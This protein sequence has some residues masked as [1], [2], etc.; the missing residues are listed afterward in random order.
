MSLP[1]IA[2]QRKLVQWLSTL[3]L[4]GLPLVR[5]GGESLLRLDAASRTL[6][7]FGARVRI[8][9]FY[10]FLL[11]VLILVL[12]F[13]LTTMVFG[14]VWCGWLCPQT[15]LTDLAEF[16]DRKAAALLP[17]K[18]LPAL[19][20]QLCFLILSFTVAANLV[21]YFIPPW[22]FF[23]RLLGGEIGMVAGIALVTV[24]L[25]LYG[26]LVLVRR[27]FCKTVCPY[28]RL[29]L[30]TMD[31]NTLTL[32]FDPRLAD[33][34]SRCGACV[35]SCPMGIDIKVGLQ[36]ECI[37]CGRCLDACRGV[38]EQRGREG[39]IHY[40]FGA[41][42]QGGGRPINGRSIL[43]AGV[44][45]LLCAVLATGIA[46]RQE[47][48]IK[49]QRGGGGEVRRL[50]EGGV[51]NFYSAY[52]ENRAAHS[53]RFTL[54]V[55]PVAGYRVELL[56]PVKDIHLPANANRRVDFIVKATPAPDAPRDLEFQLLREGK[57]VATAL[58]LLQVQ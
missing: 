20:R 48:T 50:A 47:A 43:L 36:I 29:Q 34:C 55:S 25:L 30:L 11:V 6:L 19:A 18:F 2:P 37:N 32:E 49:V 15:T 45:V 17:G 57:T 40:T 58:V 21:W 26:D 10:L 46:L 54:A 38:L 31:R 8:E 56:G 33:L 22:E 28:G 14:R 4:L 42:A 53:G 9:E 27:L 41:G 24:T 16:L 52:L 3:V 1:R 35:K 23:P 39:L 5:M 12:G 51:I 13:L 44:V 7:F